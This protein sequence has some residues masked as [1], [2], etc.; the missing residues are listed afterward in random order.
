MSW[1]DII[2]LLPLL[3]GLVRGLMRGL[4]V[5]L[6]SIAAIALGYVGARMWGAVLTTWLTQQFEWPEAVCLV[7]AYAVLFIGIALVLHLLAKLI[8]KLFQKISL[9]WLN[10]LFGGIFGMAKWAVIILGIILCVHRL[11]SQFHFMK[12]E[13]KQ[14]SI[15]YNYTTPLAEK[16]WNK[17]KAE[18][19][20]LSPEYIDENT[21]KKEQK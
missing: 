6:T 17:V 1:L 8:S 2:I 15:L 12:D 21:T 11:D 3:I 19:A 13:L 9:G 18:I 4:V 16:A 7:L 10:R 5:E 14:E 20:D